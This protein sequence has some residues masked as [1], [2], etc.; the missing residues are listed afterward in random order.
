MAVNLVDIVQYII[1]QIDLNLEVISTDGVRVYLCKTLHLTLGKIVKDDQNN[2]YRVTA[3][4][5]NEWVD[6]EPIGHANLFS[7]NILIA[8]EITYL[9]GSPS[10][11]N[12]E[13]LTLLSS[14]TLEK[15]PFIW[16]LEPYEYEDTSRESAIEA[17]YRAR[18]F[19][20]DWA[21]APEWIN[22]QHNNNA[23]KP[24][25]NLAQAFIDVINDDFT[26]K[27]L[28]DYTRKVR[29]R[30]GVEVTDQGSDR[31]IIDEDLSG[32]ELAPLIEV[33]DLAGCK[34]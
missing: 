14:R 24:M 21:D 34:C 8:P 5:N 33:Y 1:D 27:T 32:V 15:T 4:S 17:A 19:F 22:D 6:L 9:H 26:F 29:P 2:E 18:L 11:T 25:E 12:Q 31:K 10:S 20:M 7:G 23:I 3:I 30:F 13:Y 16:L 28:S